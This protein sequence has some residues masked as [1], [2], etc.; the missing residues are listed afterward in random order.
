M[1]GHMAYLENWKKASSPEHRKQRK[2]WCQ[3]SLE[4]MGRIQMMQGP[5]GHIKNF[6]IYPKSIEET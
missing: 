5:T 2:E 4:K 6:V 1:E 3:V